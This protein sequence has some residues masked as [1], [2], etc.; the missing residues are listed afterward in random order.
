[1]TP[2]TG[3][4]PGTLVHARGRE[5]VVLPESEA[6]LLVLRPLGGGDDDTAAILPGLEP[7][8]PAL[9]P[10][11]GPGD[12]G[13]AASAGLLRTAL[14][15]GF[16]SSAGPFRSLAGLAVEPRAYQYVPLLMA[17][18][19]DVVRL[20]IADDVGIGKTIEAGLI[21]A[22]L[23]AQ[24]DAA[25]LAVL[26][27]PALAEQWQRE[28]RDKFAIDAELVLPSTVT[29]LT[30][31]LMLN[32]SLF[33]RHPYVVVSTDF[34]KSPVRRHE[35]VNHCP[36]LVIVDEAHG[37]VADGA[38]GGT[39]ART[40][41][42]DLLRAVAADSNRHLILISGTPHSGK[43]D[44][45][46][47]LLGLCDP[48][49]ATVDLDDV[50]GREF[51]ARHYVQR[52]RGD[53][54][55]YLGEDTAFPSDRHTREAPYDLSPA[56]AAFF[57]RIVEYAREQ[58]VDT[59][60]PD[61]PTLRQ[62]IRW[63]SALALLRTLASSPRAAAATLRTRVS[64]TEA[65][66]VE[67]AD[68]LGRATV[69]DAAD[70]ET[71][72]SLD[73]TP[74]G[75][76]AGIDDDDPDDDAGP[77]PNLLSQRRRLLALAVTAEDLV[78]PK[79]DRKLA[80]LISELK[81]LLADGYDPIVFCRF[82]D[83]AEYL[84]EH[85]TGAVGR[86]VTVAAVT[87]R[88]PPELREARIAELAANP[89][90]HVLVATD[91]LSEGVNL[92]DNFQ[93][94]VHYDLAWNPTRHE[95]REGRV[96]R[97]G[98]TRDIVRA[99]TIYGRD[100]QIDGIVLDVLIRKHQA[101]RAATG[102]SVPVPDESDGVVEA[103]MEGLVLRGRREASQ[104]TLDLGLERRRDDLHREW[105]SAAE[106]ERR[107]QTKYAQEA[108][109]PDAVAREVAAARA[110]LGG[111]H[112]VEAFTIETLRLLGGSVTRRDF[113][114]QAVTTT[115]PIGLRDTLPPGH[116]EPLPLHRDVPVPRGHALLA[117]TDP[118]VEAIARYV[119]DTALDPA[120][121]VRAAA[122][123]GV[124]RTR[125]VTQRTTLLLVRFRFHL[126][127][128]ARGGVRQLVTEEARFLAFT[129]APDKAVWLDPGATDALTTASADANVAPD[130]AA[131]LTGRVVAG[132][133]ALAPAL[134]AEADRLAA[135][136]LDAHRR[137]RVGASAPR[138]G[139]AVTAQKPP[140][141]LGV[142]IWLPVPAGAGAS[143]PEPSP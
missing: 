30:R 33:N 46:R 44:G 133:P 115:L 86:G 65:D 19:Q 75:D 41:R 88:L 64:A 100:N 35:F 110:A 136:L 89:G 103:L 129:G 143:P 123:A 99:V 76:A 60:G 70:D 119:L 61:G 42:Y 69:L 23:L 114:W 47:N 45:F 120:A 140:D 27:S 102:V 128:P 32:E 135:E 77:R 125:A 109:H 108:I 122:R 111:H 141:I 36:E 11:P 91:C 12:L 58:V 124:A 20:L 104:L 40:Q 132:L 22:E 98:Q 138:R 14:R 3:F 118:H 82:I 94:V 7:V 39:R 90:R 83:T 71:L 117:R 57:D 4:A 130:Q 9:F 24:G 48:A 92:Q 34:I 55:Q 106:R 26:C 137:V 101:I 116:Q 62:R 5:W 13:D 28:L 142:Y 6:D 63:W 1:V 38:G 81:A 80:T 126:D 10:P 78:G 67:E 29:R 72:E 134:D 74:G 56:Y 25:R 21:A 43:D 15:I 68:A 2:P 95:Q 107:S 50:K 113:G 127:L 53:I 139:L 18:R 16:R 79:Q 73:A 51:L 85:L 17:L 66:T 87:G 59:T 96:D 54:R 31:G 105:E 8:R 93:A 112:D 37:A 131:D 84:A 49:L 121:G 52:R 97:F